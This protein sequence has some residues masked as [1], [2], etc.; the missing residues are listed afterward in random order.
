MELGANTKQVWI[1]ISESDHWQGQVLSLAILELLRHEGCA[2]GTVLRGIAGFGA[3][4]RIRTTA[5]VELS[6][7]LPIV[8]TFVDR[9]DRV[10]R[11]LPRIMTMVTEGLITVTPVEVVKYTHRALGPFPTGLTVADVMMRDGHT[12]RPDTPVAEVVTLLLNQDVRAVP[13][14]DEQQRVLG[15]ITDGDLLRRGGLTLPLAVQQVLPPSERAAALVALRDQPHHAADLMTPHPLTLPRT[16][17]LAQ[18]ARQL[19]AHDLKRMPVVDEHDRLVGMLSR[20]DLLSTVVERLRQRAPDQVVLPVGAPQTVA[21]VMLPDV[22][23]V[24]PSTPLTEVL[25][26]LLAQP[27]SRVLVVDE[28]QRVV[29]IITDG[30][31]LRRAARRVQVPMMQ[32]LVNWLGGQY[33]E[34]LTVAAAGRSAAEVM[35]SPVVTVRADTPIVDAVRLIMAERVK[36]IPVVDAEGRLEGLVGRA[37]LLRALAYRS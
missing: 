35:T 17:R 13:V 25:N 30:D 9:A 29:G 8:V 26:Q 7:D 15:V 20:D 33:S 11:V 5:Q 37:G 18:A 32:W 4:S 28:Q 10:D 16:A 23:T 19:A 1:F 12:V 6:S 27:Q 2:G 21:D 31:V 22:P 36:R 14:V 34:E 3:H 24:L